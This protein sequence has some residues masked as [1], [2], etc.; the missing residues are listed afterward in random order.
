MMS[1]AIAALEHREDAV[2]VWRAAN[3]ARGNPP[4]AV[5]VA[6]VREKLDDDEA[7]VVIG[8]ESGRV[9][10]MALAEPGREARGQGAIAPGL[11]HVSMVFVD[12][13]RWGRGVGT[14]LLDALHYAMLERGWRTSSLWT[15]VTNRRARRLYERRGY[16]QTA[17]VAQLPGADT[18][19]RYEVALD[20]AA[21]PRP[22]GAESLQTEHL[23][24]RPWQDEHAELLS[25]LSRVPEVMPYIARA[26]CG[27]RTRA[28]RSLARRP[29]TGRST[30]SDGE[31]PRSARP[32]T[33]SGSS[34]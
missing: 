5:R 29:R 30:P 7:C 13:E 9:V 8:I 32:V 6:R 22:G 4:S 31:Q 34:S 16:R 26:S 17:E 11:G 1:F 14:S 28:R 25:R 2:R 24:L 10:A 12:P 33:W 21:A 27:L 3:I 19:I 15:R 23:I 20:Q 18:I